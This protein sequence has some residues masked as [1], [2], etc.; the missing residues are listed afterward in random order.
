MPTRSP[1]GSRPNGIT[2]PLVK[3][4]RE[5]GLIA[6]GERRLVAVSGGPASTAL[7]L[8]LHEEGHDVAAAHCDHALQPG[9]S[10]VADHVRGRCARLGVEVLIERRERPMPRGSVQAGA[11]TLRYDFLERARAQAGADVV[12]IGHTADDVVEGIVLHLLRG[13]GLAGMRGMPARRGVVLPP[14]L[15]VWRSEGADSLQRRGI[16]AL[17]EPSNSNDAY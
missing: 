15:S 6:A 1:G 4:I 8:A 14:L 7:L 17:Q 5:S 16:E 10:N 11:R 12:A 13:C 9:S 3:G 2:D